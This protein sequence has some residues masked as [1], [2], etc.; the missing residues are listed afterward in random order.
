MARGNP[1]LLRRLVGNLIENA[2]LYMPAGGSVAVRTACDGADCVLTVQD[3]GRGMTPEE[4]AHVFERFY[5]AEGAGEAG[6]KGSGLGLSICR[7][8]A[9]LHGGSIAVES[10]PGKGSTFTARLP[11]RPS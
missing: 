6:A 9:E 5:R 2:I 8:I 10:R 1:V 7:R 11:S 4:L 3:T